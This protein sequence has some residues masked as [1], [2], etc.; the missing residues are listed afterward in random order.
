MLRKIFVSIILLC[1]FISAGCGNYKPVADGERSEIVTSAVSTQTPIPSVSIVSEFPPKMEKLPAINDTT[2][3]KEIEEAC[4]LAADGRHRESVEAFNRILP[5]YKDGGVMEAYILAQRGGA[6]GHLNDKEKAEKDFRDA[7]NLKISEHDK[8]VILFQIAR[9]YCN[10]PEKNGIK[11][12]EQ[13]IL[14]IL[15]RI[16]GIEPDFDIDTR[17]GTKARI[18]SLNIMANTMNR[19]GRYKEA[20]D[21]YDRILQVNPDDTEAYSEKTRAYYLGG[22]IEKAREAAKKCLESFAGNK[23][24]SKKPP[25]ELDIVSVYVHI[26]LKDYDKA[27]ETANFLIREEK[28]NPYPFIDRAWVYYKMGKLKQA[29]ADLEKARQFSEGEIYSTQ[30]INDLEKLLKKASENKL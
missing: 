19:R 3:I 24:M 22:N 5:K 14:D 2:G 25:N 6:Y 12:R 13:E 1:I 16:E 23:T 15:T 9:E 17:I 27:L 26:S 7:L 10:Y 20:V 29:K 18:T 28:N 4:Q 8:A 30:S 11:T 21:Y